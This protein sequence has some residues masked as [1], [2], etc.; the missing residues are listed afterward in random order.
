[1]KSWLTRTDRGARDGYPICIKQ[2]NKQHKNKEN[3]THTNDYTQKKTLVGMKIQ[4][5]GKIGT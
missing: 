4:H 3:T 2:P 1:M 5:F